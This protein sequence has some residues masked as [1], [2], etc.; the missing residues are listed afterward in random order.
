MAVPIKFGTD[1]SS[2][3]VGIS[4]P[5]FVIHV[6]GAIALLRQ[7]YIVSDDAQRFLMNAIVGETNSSPITVILNWQAERKK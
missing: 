3:A 5:L 4:A 7:Q 2:V 1:G 6:G